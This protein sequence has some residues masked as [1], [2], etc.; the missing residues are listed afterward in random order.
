MHPSGW[1][2]PAASDQEDRRGAP[3]RPAGGE[4]IA[5]DRH[6]RAQLIGR[7][8]DFLR[9]TVDWFWETDANLVLTSVSRRIAAHAGIPAPLLVGRPLG[10]LGRFGSDEAAHEAVQ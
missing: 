2:P 8:E 6:K 1:G 7:Y 9:A 4:T 10:E 5:A 3:E